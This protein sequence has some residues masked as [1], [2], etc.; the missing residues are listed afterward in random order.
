MLYH[1]DSFARNGFETRIVAHRGALSIRLP[2]R[3]SVARAEYS[4]LRCSMLPL[5]SAPPDTLAARS[6]V[7]FD[8]LDTPLAWVSRLPRPLFLLFAPLKILLGAFGLYRTLM[9]LRSPP[10]SLF[11]QVRVPLCS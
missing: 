6:N 11:V 7:H 8:Y 4:L 5:G 3:S 10:G 9:S 1:A 2:S